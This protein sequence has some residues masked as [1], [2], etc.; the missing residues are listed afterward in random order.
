MDSLE[1]TK[2]QSLGIEEE[3]DSIMESIAEEIRLDN[4]IY[5]KA[6]RVHRLA[7]KSNIVVKTPR[8]GPEAKALIPA[9]ITEDDDFKK[10]I[11]KYG[12]ELQGYARRLVYRSRESGEV[13]ADI[14]Q[15]SWMVAYRFMKSQSWRPIS[16]AVLGHLSQVPAAWKEGPGEEKQANVRA[17][18][19]AIVHN[20]AVDHLMKEKAHPLFSYDPIDNDRACNEM[21][22]PE[23]A[24]MYK[25][26]IAEIY[27]AL[28]KLPEQI[29]KV[30]NL[31]IQGYTNVEIAKELSC[32]PNTVASHVRR[33]RQYLREVLAT[34]KN[35]RKRKKPSS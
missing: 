3:D 12:E 30:F 6:R 17:W 31:I 16:A 8:I 7:S 5:G 15:E 18:L 34:K 32:P 14:V 13:A 27:Q 35:M 20:K 33:G 23:L 9:P 10:L 21:D 11:D 1:E 22:Q 26:H 4:A 2:L 19:Y 29:S 28:E 24:F 25:E